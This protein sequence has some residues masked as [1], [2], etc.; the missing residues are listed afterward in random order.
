MINIKYNKNYLKY[1]CY[2]HLN[3]VESW[4]LSLLLSES[5][6]V[7]RDNIPMNVSIWTCCA[8]PPPPLIPVKVTP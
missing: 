4:D 7:T 8:P 5:P 3:K 6:V 1:E 2:G